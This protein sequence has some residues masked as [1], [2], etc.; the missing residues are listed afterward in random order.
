MLST[1]D[2]SR[3]SAGLAYVYPVLS[4]RSGGL[5][6]GI[7]LNPNNACN[8]RCVYCQVP[9]LVR[10]AAPAI[11]LELFARELG[12]FLDEVLTGDFFRRVQIPEDQ[13]IVRDIAISGN[14]EPTGSPQFER[15]IELIV[16]LARNRG[17]IANRSQADAGA[18]PP[19]R[20]S[21]AREP[22]QPRSDPGFK[23]VLITNGSL[24]RRETV[25]NGLTR[26]GEAGGETWFK[27]DSATEDGLLRINGIRLAPE[28]VLLNLASA[29]ALC[30][31]WLQTCLFAYDGQP[32]AEVERQAY[33]RFLAAVRQ[34]K[35]PLRGVLLYGLARP[36]MQPEAARL[37]ALPAAWMEAFA[38]DVRNM[39]LEARLSV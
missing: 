11:D 19:S 10:G 36:S 26:W 9:N 33:F 12:G 16:E 38:E 15:A 8:W 14:G 37:S 31:T 35:I 24:A 22:E 4:R 20:P 30:P 29:A 25:R 2:H 6:I 13:R 5:S 32:P 17:L 39:G 1:T 7:N 28:S 3:D 23:L 27:L 21:G 18:N 34:R